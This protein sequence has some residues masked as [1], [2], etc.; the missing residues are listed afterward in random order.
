MQDDILLLKELKALL[1]KYGA[2]ID[3]SSGAGSDWSGIYN[4]KI[5]IKR[6]IPGSPHK[7][8]EVYSPEDFYITS[9]NI[10]IKE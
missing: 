9:E 3:I 8:R 1:D 6:T 7:E 5:V 4:E 10:K 2:S